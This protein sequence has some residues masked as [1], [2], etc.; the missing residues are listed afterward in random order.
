LFASTYYNVMP[1]LI[2]T[3]KGI[4]SSYAPLGAVMARK[5]IAD[6]FNDGPGFLHGLTFGGHPVCTA[7]ALANLDIMLEEDLPGQAKATGAYL[8]AQLEARIGNH[9]NVGDIR[10]AGLFLGIEVVAD[11]TTKVSP[12]YGADVLNWMTSEMRDQGFIVRNDS[13]G[14]PTTQLCP[15]LVITRE[16]CDRSVD[17]LEGVFNELGR[18]MGTVGTKHPTA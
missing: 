6:E 8:R 17:M 10:G 12:E 14:D 4:T 3:A 18:R 7:A 13:R 1:D 2:T 11:K 5:S 15:P 16:E 9:P